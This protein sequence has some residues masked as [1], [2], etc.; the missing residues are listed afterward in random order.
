VKIAVLGGGVAGVS[1]AHWLSRRYDVTLFEKNDYVGGHTNTVV[2]ED[3]PDAGTPVD[4]GFIVCNDRTYPT[5]HKFLR[6]LDVPVRYADMSFG[7][8]CEESG[9]QY[10]GRGGARGL[11]AQKRNLLRPWYWKMLGEVVRFGREA[12]ADLDSGVLSRVPLGDYLED[13]G[14]GARFRRHY[15]FPMGSAIWSTPS[16][17]MLAFPAETLARFFDNHGLLDLRDRPRWQTVVGGSH[18]YVKA[19]RRVFPGTVVTG[20][21]ARAVSRDGDSVSV[22]FSDGETRTFDK[23]VIAAHADEALKMLADPS[24]DERRLLGPWRY[25]KNRTVL[26]TDASVLPPIRGAWA[27]WNYHRAKGSDETRTTLTY[28]MNNLQGLRARERYCVTLNPEIEIDPSRVIRT[29][30]YMHPLFSAEAVRTQAELPALQGVRGTYFTGSY[31][32][33]GFHEDAVRASAAVVGHFG[34]RP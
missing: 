24:D 6:E 1:A 11:F 17:G 20:K 30:D 9:L 19:F 27:S 33:Y 31:H 7:Y 4:T 28:D 2:V 13:R 10:S 15:L 18:S 22:R 32:G 23:V 29:V 12:K 26:H 8:H 34:I 5:F 16:S 25:E 14:Y 3:G 21:A